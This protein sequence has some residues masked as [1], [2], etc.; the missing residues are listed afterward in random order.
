MGGQIGTHKK[1]Y[2]QR[3]RAFFQSQID[4]KLDPRNRGGFT[5]I[6]QKSLHYENTLIRD[7]LIKLVKL[8]DDECNLSIFIKTL[9][10]LRVFFNSMSP[11]ATELLDTSFAHT[12]HCQNVKTAH[13]LSGK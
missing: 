13:M 6:A 4:I 2:F 11:I 10:D 8:L 7:S 1:T 12:E 5:S 9:T 3:M